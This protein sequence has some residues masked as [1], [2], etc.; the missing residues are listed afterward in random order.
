[1]GR[2]FVKIFRN[3][4]GLR[5]V[6]LDGSVPSQLW[7]RVPPTLESGDSGAGSFF[8]KDSG[9]LK[10]NKITFLAGGTD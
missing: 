9:S 4:L 2:Y 10:S 7:P 3:E 6:R 8:F 5:K 1:M